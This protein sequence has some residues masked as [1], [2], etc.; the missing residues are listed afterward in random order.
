MNKTESFNSDGSRNPRQN[1]NQK[2]G[3]VNTENQK[4]SEKKKKKPNKLVL[5]CGKLCG[6]G[7]KKDGEKKKKKREK[8]KSKS[9]KSKRERYCGF[10]KRGRR[11]KKKKKEDDEDEPEEY[12]EYE[13]SRQARRDREYEAYDQ[14][15]S[16]PAEERKRTRAERKKE[17]ALRRKES[18][19]LERKVSYA[20]NDRYVD[21][22]RNRSYQDR[23]RLRRDVTKSCC[24]LCAENSLAITGVIGKPV[25]SDKSVEAYK[26]EKIETSCSPMKLPMHVR[27]VKSSLRV[28][29][30]DTCTS[31]GKIP[32]AKK[33]KRKK[34]RLFPKIK[35]STCPNRKPPPKQRTVGCVTEN[36]SKYKKPKQEKVREP[37]CKDKATVLDSPVVESFRKSFNPIILCSLGH[38]KNIMPVSKV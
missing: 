8:K 28:K 18:D 22:P 25:C 19:R 21:D 35:K 12:E 31:Y 3:S 29:V 27:T 33:K 1:S 37:C 20:K 2:D 5:W 14:S 36:V 26:T 34:F 4:D 7:K 30:Q 24:F 13:D 6:R 11:K 23:D 38:L 15:D 17:K 10:C 32:K 9:K 16:I